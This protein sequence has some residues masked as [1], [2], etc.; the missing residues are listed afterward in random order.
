MLYISVPLITH[1]CPCVYLWS[2][3]ALGTKC[4]HSNITHGDHWEFL[5]SHV[6]AGFQYRHWVTLGA[7][8][9]S[10]GKVSGIHLTP[11][12]SS[13]FSVVSEENKPPAHQRHRT[14]I[15]WRLATLPGLGRN[16]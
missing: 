5:S 14:L 7:K 12:P 13:H 11:S 15:L 9:L 4:S 3:S 6:Y 2:S 1:V 8:V 16:E 10:K